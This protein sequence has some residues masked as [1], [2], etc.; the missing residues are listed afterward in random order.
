MDL[1]EEDVFQILKIVEKSSFDFFQLEMGDLKVIVNKGETVPDFTQIKKVT[2][3]SDSEPK[4]SNKAVQ[5]PEISTHQEMP[6]KKQEPEKGPETLP[7][8]GFTS[9]T[10]PLLG[11]FYRRPRPGADP[12]VQQGSSVREDTVVGL[13]EV[14]K[15]FTSVKAGVR[16]K[17]VESLVENGQ[18]VEYGNELFLVKPED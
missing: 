7:A 12:F 2:V 18:F 15:V 3:S 10:A 8:E 6:E 13:I 14:M 16:G 17:I 5:A 9:I 11:T 1:N 4:I